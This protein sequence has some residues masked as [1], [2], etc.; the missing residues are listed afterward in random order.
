[1]Q[2]PSAGIVGDPQVDAAARSVVKVLGTACGLGVEG[3]GWV[4]GDGDRGHQRARRGGPGG[5][6][7][8][9]AGRGARHRRGGRRTSTRA[10]TSRCCGSAGCSAPALALGRL[11]A[12]GHLGRR[13]RVPA[14]RALRRARRPPRG[15]A[16]GRHPGRLRPR[17]GAAV[18]HLAA[19]RRPLRQ[20]RR[21][22]G[23][24]PRQGGHDDL[25]RDHDRAARRLRRAERRRA[26]RARRRARARVDGSV[27][28]PPARRRPATLDRSWPRPS[29]SPRSP[30]S[31][32]TSPGPCP[33]QFAKHEGYLESDSHVVTWAVGHLVQLAEPDEY[34]AKYKKWR[35]ADLPIVPDDFR[36]VVRDERSRK[37]M[38][39]I[40]K[41]LQRKDVDARRQR[42]RRRPRG[43]ADLRLDATRRRASR[44]PSSGC[45]CRR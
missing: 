34:D 36:L 28:V 9:A 41:L 16:R 42:L 40:T 44:S 29:S 22:D 18:D 17:A 10:T 24:R 25:R 1:M 45:G 43:R 37:Q 12:H 33:G 14:Q 39:V 26:Q 13:P 6:A 15:H 19:R 21:P 32:A 11:A 35:M 4:A 30:P 8:A 5:H 2:A 38:T 7:R 31:D 3:S 23:R 27:R 20:L